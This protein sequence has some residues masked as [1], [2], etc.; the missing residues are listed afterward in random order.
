MPTVVVE[1][2]WMMIQDLNDDDDPV[3]ESSTDEDMPSLRVED[4][5]RFPFR[6]RLIHAGFRNLEPMPRD[7]REN[8]DPWRI[9]ADRRSMHRWQRAKLNI[10]SLLNRKQIWARLGR[11][12]S[13]IPDSERSLPE[14]MRAKAIWSNLGRL[15]QRLNTKALTAHVER[16]KGK[17]VY[18][19]PWT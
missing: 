16:K 18:K 8:D 5:L 1:G 10:T 12:L 13:Q 6:A 7:E 9:Q 17:L 2:D 11:T 15:L 19:L 3:T 4:N 14:N